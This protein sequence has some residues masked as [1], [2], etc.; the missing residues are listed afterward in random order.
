MPHLNRVLDNTNCLLAV[1]DMD[2][3]HAMMSFFR[4]S[5]GGIEYLLTTHLTDLMSASTAETGLHARHSVT[6]LRNAL[7]SGNI[8]DRDASFSFL[9]V[10]PA[11]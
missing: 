11:I 1:P 9:P 3:D 7:I 4:L 5:S 2:I 8:S 10:L 6:T